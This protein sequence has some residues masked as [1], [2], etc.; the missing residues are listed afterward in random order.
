M[1]NTRF[2][3]EG[4]YFP[5]RFN[6]KPPRDLGHHSKFRVLMR[7]HRPKPQGIMPWGPH[8]LRKKRPSNC[9]CLDVTTWKVQSNHQP[10][11][12]CE[13]KILETA[14][15]N[16]K[17]SLLQTKLLLS[18]LHNFT[19]Q[20]SSSRFTSLT[21]VA[22]QKRSMPSRCTKRSTRT[23]S[24][25]PLLHSGLEDTPRLCGKKFVKIWILPKGWR[26]HQKFHQT[27]PPM[28]G[29]CTS[30][31]SA[32]EADE[33]THFSGLIEC[34]SF[35]KKWRLWMAQWAKFDKQFGKNRR[36]LW[37]KW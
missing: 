2:L 28:F 30:V 37:S 1:D 23:T 14:R 34:A 35:T 10:Y 6:K 16:F 17:N 31:C 33:N 20:A 36:E 13:F 7:K 15:N 25:H 32:K 11:L 26:N 21:H 22:L 19:H 4:V 3:G 29:L 12:H 27:T 9:T 5:E 18:V 24:Y 8:L